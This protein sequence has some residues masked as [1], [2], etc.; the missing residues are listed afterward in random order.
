MLE[1]LPKDVIYSCLCPYLELVELA[2]CAQVSKY[3]LEM[4]RANGAF[5]HI[6]DRIVRAVPA[7]ENISSSYT[8]TYHYLK[9]AVY[10][11]CKNFINIGNTK[12][13]I[14]ILKLHPVMRDLYVN[15]YSDNDSGQVIEL[16]NDYTTI[17]FKNDL[18]GWE[19][20]YLLTMHPKSVIYNTYSNNRHMRISHFSDAYFGYLLHCLLFPR[21]K[22]IFMSPKY[23][24]VQNSIIP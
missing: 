6:K 10:G 22:T 17:V 24:Q 15:V 19:P 7:L 11:V 2:R 5:R 14:G 8:D 18:T 16:Y 21:Y 23:Y 13:V 4:F 12:I 20:K 3:W 1:G 9:F